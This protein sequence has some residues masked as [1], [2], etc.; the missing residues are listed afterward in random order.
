MTGDVGV[1]VVI[2]WSEFSSGYGCAAD[3]AVNAELALEYADGDECCAI[4]RAAGEAAGD[5]VYA[6]A[7]DGRF[8]VAGAGFRLAPGFGGPV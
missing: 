4:E 1:I 7:G 8:A 3:E 2:V 5:P 6:F